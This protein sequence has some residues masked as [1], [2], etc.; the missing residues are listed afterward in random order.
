LQGSFDH[1]SAAAGGSRS[2]TSA[3]SIGRKRA[4]G[5]RLDVAATGFFLGQSIAACRLAAIDLVATNGDAAGNW[6]AIPSTGFRRRLAASDG[7]TTAGSPGGFISGEG[8]RDKSDGRR[9]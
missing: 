9:R 6:F 3:H 5:E 2:K 1:S 8:G 7:V 4:Y